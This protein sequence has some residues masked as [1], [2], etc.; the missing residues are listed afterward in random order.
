MEFLHDPDFISEKVQLMAGVNPLVFWISNFVWDFIV[1][2][3]LATVLALILYLYD[4]RNTFHQNGGFGTLMFLYTLLGL[5][6]IPYAYIMSFPFKSDA[7][8]N[9]I[10]IIFS[11]VTGIVAP[12]A[13]YYPRLVYKPEIMSTNLGMISDIIR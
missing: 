12:L 9:S 1:Y 11:A 10:L 2:M 3:V 7:T 13:T 5:A 8:A 4:D 6:G